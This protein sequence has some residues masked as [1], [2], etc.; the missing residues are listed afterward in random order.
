MMTGARSTCNSNGRDGDES[1]GGLLLATV[2]NA[3]KR[4]PMQLHF[5]RGHHQVCGGPPSQ[6][7]FFP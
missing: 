7:R 4:S 2:R 3:E 1:Y 5:G 6:Q